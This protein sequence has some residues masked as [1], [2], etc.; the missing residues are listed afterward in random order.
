MNAP[1]WPCWKCCAGGWNPGAG[2]VCAFSPFPNSGPQEVWGSALDFS[3]KESLKLCV[4]CV[5]RLHPSSSGQTSP[6]SAHGLGAGRGWDWGS[7]DWLAAG[8]TPAPAEE[9]QPVGGRSEE[10]SD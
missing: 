4:L 8:R 3:P 7:A 1:V 2:V 9:K 6:L 5:W 10:R